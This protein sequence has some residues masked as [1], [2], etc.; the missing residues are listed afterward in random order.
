MSRGFTLVEVIVVLTV[1]SI[2]LSTAALSFPAARS[3]TA[4]DSGAAVLEAARVR[5]LQSG[6]AVQAGSATDPVLFLPDG[7]VIGP[8][9]DP[10]SGAPADSAR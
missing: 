2:A 7:R 3:G 5:A 6:Q 1:L 4:A 10:L 9:F 8:G